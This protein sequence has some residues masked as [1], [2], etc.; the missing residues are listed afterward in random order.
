MSSSETTV[1]QLQCERSDETLV[2][3]AFLCADSVIQGASLT[4]SL[5]GF[6]ERLCKSDRAPSLVEPVACPV[7]TRSCFRVDAQQLVAVD[8][9]SRTRRSLWISGANVNEE[10]Y[11]QV[12]TRKFLDESEDETFVGSRLLSLA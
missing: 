5:R 6:Y 11:F 2:L 8:L 1:R 10:Q 9:D 12:L 7:L 4:R 3:A